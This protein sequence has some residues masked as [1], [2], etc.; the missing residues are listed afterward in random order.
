M[1]ESACSRS[2]WIRPCEPIVSAAMESMLM[3]F[4]AKTSVTS[5]S[6]PVRLGEMTVIR[7]THVLH[8]GVDLWFFDSRH[9]DEM[10]DAGVGR[11]L[12]ALPQ[13]G[14]NARKNDG[15]GR[16]VAPRG[17]AGR[18]QLLLRVGPQFQRACSALAQTRLPQRTDSLP[19]NQGRKAVAR[20]RDRR[21]EAADVIDGASDPRNV[22]LAGE[23]DA[24]RHRRT[25][26]LVAAD[27][28]AVRAVG[29]IEGL[30]D[31]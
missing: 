11:E 7:C 29:E 5:A 6:T 30:A 2:M 4:R 10:R 21:I 13:F 20:P 31:R 26:K 18:P 12:P 25:Q 14:R 16:L 23:D 15:Y 27:R 28:D 19:E 1:A 8:E 17:D 22:A 24:A 3:F 9:D